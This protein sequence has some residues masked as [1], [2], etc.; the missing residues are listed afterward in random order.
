MPW[1]TRHLLALALGFLLDLAIGDPRWLPH[2]IRGVGLLIAGLEKRLRR[3]FPRTPE[4]ERAA[5]R[6]LVALTVV[7][8]AGIA[9]LLLW[10]CAAV[11]WGLALGVETVLCCYLLCTRSLRDESMKVFAALKNSGLPAARQAVSMIV[12]RDTAAL[13]EAGVARAAVETVAENTADGVAAPLLYMALGGAGAGMLYKACNTLDSMVGYQNDKYLHF[14][15]FAAKLDDV[16]NFI[17]ARLSGFV[18]ALMAPTVGGSVGRS[19][20]IFFR[21][22]LQ[23]KSPNSAH[24]EA[25]CAGALGLRL[26]GDN[27][28]FGKLVH[29]P[30]IGDDL[31]SVRAEDIPLS[32]RLMYA[33]AGALLVLFCLLPLAVLL[34]F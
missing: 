19:L 17:P 26:G 22:R 15:R 18:M 31:H 14:G 9:Q 16:L 32:C 1:I 11:H 20:K 29:K 7:I 10:A 25:A 24:T 27:Y 4:G 33:T 2:P 3:A 34:I 5:G 12:G 13:D 30:G 8:S 21:D 6:V 23:H 28:Y